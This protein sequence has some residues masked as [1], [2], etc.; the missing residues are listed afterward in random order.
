MKNILK[1]YTSNPIVFCLQ[2]QEIYKKNDVVKYTT[3]Y[4]KVIELIIYK[5][6]FSKNGLNY[7]SYLRGDGKNR[8]T[9][10]E[11]KIEKRKKWAEAREN[12]S[13]QYFEASKEGAY[14][15]ALGEPIKIGHHSESRH[16]ALIE[17][18]WNRMGKS[19][20][21]SDKAKEHIEKAE[22][23]EAIL[24]SELP[25]DTPDCLGEIAVRLEKAEELHL[26][27]KNN[28]E[29]RPHSFAL[30]DAKKKVNDL[31]K[32]LDIA[33]KLWELNTDNK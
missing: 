22:N 17:K 10:L 30:A 27:Y 4:G 11:N 31:I 5:L 23:L 28:P 9:I 6:I 24:N 19:V 1:K 16:R 20:E 26:F 13:N 29:K 32:K 14:F 25:L 33:K 3:K 18:N 15:L 2:S 12:K 21:C 8:K 7:Y